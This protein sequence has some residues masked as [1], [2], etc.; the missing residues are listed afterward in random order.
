MIV[1]CMICMQTV[2]PQTVSWQQQPCWEA[3]ELFGDNLLKVEQTGQWGLVDFDGTTILP[4]K[5]AKITKLNEGR[6]LILDD[7]GRLLSLGDC[8]GKI[9]QV[10]GYWFVDEAWPCFTNGLLAVKNTKGLWGYLNKLGKIVIKEKYKNA[11]PFFFGYASVCESGNR[12]W[13]LINDKGRPIDLI[14]GK[15]RQKK[16]S[17]ASSFTKIDDNVPL[18]FVIVSDSVYLIDAH[19]CAND[20]IVSK[21][22]ASFSGLEN[23]DLFKCIDVNRFVEI[24]VNELLE[25]TSVKDETSHRCYTSSNDTETNPKVQGIK[26][27]KDGTIM[28][29]KLAI[30]PQFQEAVPINMERMAVKK[31]DKW[32]LLAFNNESP[33]A[34]ILFDEISIQTVYHAIP[35]S[36][37][38][39]GNNDN[40]RAYSID[41]DGNITFWSINAATNTFSIPLSQLDSTS[42]AVGVETDG[43][44]LAPTVFNTIVSLGDGF[45]VTA[46]KA[47]VSKNGK[48]SFEL[49]IYNHTEQDAMPFDVVVNNNKERHFDGLQAKQSITIPVEVPVKIPALED[50]V[51]KSIK[52]A[53]AENGMPERT[54]K[55]TIKFAKAYIKG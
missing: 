9:V 1:V 50:Y 42:I 51:Y 37:Q 18:A 2:Y 33:S 25:I 5:Y 34:K 49:T 11:F 36:F 54:Y 48:A 46:P 19:G 20:A 13:H 32:G 44:V 17:F 40:T 12:G 53:I 10:D 47:V 45:I 35:L 4:C 22:G 14:N 39:M 29:G 41:D 52:V 55:V 16:F 24:E 3:V 23:E 15:Q 7:N 21:N 27:E 28:V 38:I 43:I 26:I 6:F 31:N 8:S 30:F